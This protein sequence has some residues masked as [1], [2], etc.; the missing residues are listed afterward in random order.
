MGCVSCCEDCGRL[1]LRDPHALMLHAE[2]VHGTIGALLPRVVW[3][4]DV[5]TLKR[6]IDTSAQA[7]NAAVQNCL[8]LPLDEKAAWIRWFEAWTKFRAE[9]VPTF[10]SANVYD[11]A[12]VYQSQLAEW[13]EQLKASCKVP[14]PKVR[15]PS[16]EG[17]EQ[18]SLV[19]WGAAA[20]I[21]VAVVYG[22]R[23]V[24]K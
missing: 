14:G 20:V 17:S 1:A 3:P 16:T 21:A 12:E 13:Q 15:D 8:T 2:Q 9:S 10:G 18:I 4:S 23:L 22:V 6:Q 24:I 11:T 7:T 19:K 5:E